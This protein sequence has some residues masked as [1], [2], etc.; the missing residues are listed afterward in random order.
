MPITD[1]NI[2]N[3][4]YNN[5]DALYTLH[6]KYLSLNN[7]HNQDIF[8]SPL[9]QLRQKLSSIKNIDNYLRKIITFKIQP[10]E[11]IHYINSLGQCIN[12]YEYISKFSANTNSAISN[13]SNTSTNSYQS[14]ID[15]LPSTQHIENVINIKNKF[16]TDFILDNLNSNIWKCIESNPFI[17]GI[18]KTLDNIQIDIDN[19]RMFL[20]TLFN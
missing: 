6:I 1:V 10:F 9:Y 4:R 7:K 3:T 12:V 2:L 17:K 16:N 19:D 15:L 13:D 5:I 11:I 20:D 18:N 8:G 14:I